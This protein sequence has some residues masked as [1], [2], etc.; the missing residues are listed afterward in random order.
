MLVRAAE[1][2]CGVKEQPIKTYD[3]KKEYGGLFVS[4]TGL[5]SKV[6]LESGTQ[7]V[8]TVS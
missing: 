5:L 8:P 3:K 1:F 7:I 2:P 6:W 4:R